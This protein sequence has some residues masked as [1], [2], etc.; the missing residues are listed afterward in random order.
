MKLVQT[1]SCLQRLRLRKGP[2]SHKLYSTAPNRLLHVL[3]IKR[4][5]VSNVLFG[6]YVAAVIS[7][8]MAYPVS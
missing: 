7:V 1:L 5:A 2:Q 6:L 4:I 8:L 3:I